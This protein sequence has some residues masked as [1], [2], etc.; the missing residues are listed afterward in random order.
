VHVVNLDEIR[1]S[2]GVFERG[3]FCLLRLLCIAWK[4]SL[5]E[6]TISKR[7]R[8]INLGPYVD[9]I[10]EYG[11]QYGFNSSELERLLKA[12]S[13]KNEVDQSSLTTL[14]KNLYPAE[15]VP[16]NICVIA[17]GSLGQGSTKPSFATQ[18]GIL[19]WMCNIQQLL[20]EPEFLLR[21]Y[22]VLFNH[23]DILALR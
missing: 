7:S 9:E 21:F 15:R 5:P 1:S 12:I 20:E 22:S 4:Q 16:P 23:L 8:S 18:S 17:I 19:R 3:W 11:Y 13:I 10:S 6:S 2:I 14:L